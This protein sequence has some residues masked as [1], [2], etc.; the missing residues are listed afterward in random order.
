SDVIYSG[1]VSAA[2]EGSVLGY[3]ALAASLVLPENESAERP[4]F[5]SA[6]RVAVELTQSLLGRPMPTGVLLNVNVPNRPYDSLTGVK[7][8]RLGFTQWQDNFEARHDPRGRPYYWIGGERCG[9]DD[10][11]DS[12][13][14]AIAVGAVSVTP[15]H[16]DV[17]DY[18]SFDY[19]RNLP[20]NAKRLPDDLGNGPVGHVVA[21]RKARGRWQRR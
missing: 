6:A 21:S 17:T 10:I 11:P 4:H 20:I 18:R 8:C 1:T 2:M 9:H 3:R 14:N 12:D 16:Y 15:V 19:V 13:T 7:L 5:E